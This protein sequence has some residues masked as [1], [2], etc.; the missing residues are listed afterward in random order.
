[1]KVRALGYVGVESPEAKQWEEFGP[2]ILGLQLVDG[3]QPGSVYLRMDER[4]HRLAVH[5][6]PKDRLAYLGWEMAGDDDLAEAAEVLARAGCAVAEGT[7]EECEER[8]VRRII[9]V[10]DPGGAR[11]EFFYGQLS[12]PG[13]FQPGRPLSGFVTGAQGLGHVVCVVPDLAAAARFYKMLGFKKSDE[14]YAFI[15]AHFFHCNPR[16]HTL[17]LTEIPRVRGLHHIMMQLKDFDDVGVAY[18]LVQAR[19]IPLTMTLG[20]HPNDRMVSF[21]VRTPSG[22]E[23]EYG[24]GAVEV[25]EDWTVTQYDAVS[26]WGHKMVGTSPPGALEEAL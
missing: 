24:W 8:A 2:E 18:D 7:E 6:G 12:L 13:Q 14:I 10:T 19:N 4:H 9:S 11:H 16:H 22:F 23:I 17:A 26:V 21:Y 3:D 15:D 25:G 5:P 1:M 20:R